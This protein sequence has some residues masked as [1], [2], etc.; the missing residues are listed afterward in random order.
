[1]DKHNDLLLQVKKGEIEPSAQQKEQVASIPG[2]KAQIAEL[3]EL[4]DLYIKSNPDY[5]N[6]AMA[7]K[8]KPADVAEQVEDALRMVAQV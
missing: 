3:Q 8:V 5:A 1:M 6:K 7:A 2:L 4:C